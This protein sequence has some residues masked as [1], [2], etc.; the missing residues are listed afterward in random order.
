LEAVQQRWES[1]VRY[2]EEAIAQALDPATLGLLGDAYGSLGDSTRAHEYYHAMEV[3]VL[4]QPGPFHR[5]WSLFL[6]DHDR[7]IPAVLAKVSEEIET[8]RDVYGYD[9]LAW[10]LHRSGR[11]S[12]ARV[13]MMRA[14]R[15]GTKDAILLYH[16][17]VIDLALGDTVA[18]HRHLTQALSI[19]PIWHPTQ[20]R[21]ARAL[22]D[23][24]T[25]R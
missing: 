15:L 19:N 22:L 13:P 16:A 23:S 3:T 20:P 25:S 9:L 6:L 14:L 21:E 24:L 8:R 10:A 5:A 7:D 1:A 4:N 12:E 17:G 18:A 11:D 2:G